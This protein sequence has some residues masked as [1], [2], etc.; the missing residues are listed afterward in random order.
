L[1][2]TAAWRALLT[3][4]H[5]PRSQPGA[6]LVERPILSPGD[7]NIWQAFGFEPRAGAPGASAQDVVH[8]IG[9]ENEHVVAEVDAARDAI[10][11]MVVALMIF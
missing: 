4:A 7:Q 8:E 5:N 6:A 11:A 9:V 1:A 2:A 3:L 10:A